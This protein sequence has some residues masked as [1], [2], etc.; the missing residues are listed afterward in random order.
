VSLPSHHF[1]SSQWW[2][3]RATT[4][5]T[6]Y[7]M[8][9]RYIAKYQLHTYFNSLRRARVKGCFGGTRHLITAAIQATSSYSMFTFGPL[10]NR[11]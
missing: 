7:Q 6:L 11:E 3:K 10:T 4:T 2:D 1:A 8:A 5:S 9:F